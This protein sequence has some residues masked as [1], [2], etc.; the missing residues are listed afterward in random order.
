MESILKK[1][2]GIPN[3]EEETEINGIL[4][5]AMNVGLTIAKDSM[6]GGDMNAL[7]IMRNA[8][9]KGSLVN[10]TQIVS[11]VGQQNIGGQRIPASLSGKTRT[12]PHFI[13]NDHSAE[14]RGFVSN[15][16]LKG[17]TP[18]ESFFHAA[19]GR[20]GIIST[21]IKSVTYDTAI[22]VI[23]NEI[24]KT[25]KIGE[26]VDKHILNANED[27]IERYEEMEMEYLDISLNNTVYIPTVDD[28]GVV[29]WGLI[30]A[31]T[32]HLP[33]ENLY[34]IV[35]EFG[36][37]VT[38]AESKSLIVFNHEN[39]KLEHKHMIDVHEGDLL[40]V[41]QFLPQFHLEIVE[42]NIPSHF[43][44]NPGG[45]KKFLCDRKH[46]YFLGALISSCSFI[47]DNVFLLKPKNGYTQNMYE[48][49]FYV[50]D[51]LKVKGHLSEEGQL[52][53]KSTILSKFIYKM[54]KN[55]NEIVLTSLE[56]KEGILD[57]Y[58][59]FCGICDYESKSLICEED[60]C[61]SIP[62]FSIIN[63]LCNGFGIFT[64]L[65]GSQKFQIEGIFLAIMKNTV[66]ITNDILQE[67]INE[68]TLIYEDC[69]ISGSFGNICLDKIKSIEK[70]KSEG[71]KLY[72]LTIP[73]TLN[74]C[75]ANGLHVADTSDTGY[76]QK[77]I[78]RKIEDCKAYIDGTVRIGNGRIIQFLYG[79]DGLNPKFLYVPKGLDFPFFVNPINISRRLNSDAIQ[80]RIVSEK[81]KPRNLHDPEI[82]L[83]LSFINAGVPYL[84]SEVIEN[85]T[86]VIRIILRKLLE[87]EDL[88][89][90]ENMIPLFCSEIKNM[91]EGAKIHYGEMVGLHTAS[92][93]GEPTTQ[94]MLDSV[95]YETEILVRN[96][97][98]L[99]KKL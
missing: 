91:Y 73:S 37:T 89:I 95:T 18:A 59:S 25:V 58:F 65:C 42:F 28:Y 76:I 78:G 77:K 8:G 49:I 93:I 7:N 11:F 67:R 16:Y 90:Y 1:C 34:N 61:P 87:D 63:M 66:S 17:L 52:Y 10:L 33:T 68:C 98:E 6:V 92:F 99:F 57:G 30:S 83:L 56:F 80:K 97:K 88:V 36:R 20:T 21:S 35:T 24:P 23:E 39:S 96:R 51:K 48:D 69:E 70:I 82:N 81:D 14:A 71:D 43:I 27:K 50:L 94:M 46:G 74:F 72:D 53:I 45:N 3:Q 84:K 19:A 26:W 31:V 62:E 2:D 5:S 55:L 13:E 40:P 79:D 32:R 9:A 29:S 86:N 47:K 44:E 60:A 22:F 38:V 54:S 85:S 15:G 12:L 4:N 64:R 75:L 41:T